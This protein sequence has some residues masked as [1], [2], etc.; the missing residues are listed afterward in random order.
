MSNTIDFFQSE[1]SELAIPGLTA[2]VLL[3]GL[4]CPYL[5]LIEIVRSGWPNFSRARLA[6]NPAAC[7]D[8][9]YTT[10]EQIETILPFGKTVCVQQIYNSGT[11]GISL[12]ALPIFCGQIQRIESKFASDGEGVEIIASDFSATLRRITV[13]GRWVRNIDGSVLFMSGLDTVFNE[14]GKPNAAQEPIKDN[15]NN[16]TVF[17]AGSSAGKFWTYA[18]VINYLFSKYLH[19]GQLQTPSIEQLEALTGKQIIRDLDLTG[20]NLL[21]A[22]YCCCQRVGLNFKFVPR[23]VGTGCDQAA[24]FYK[25]GNGREMELNCQYSNQLFSISKTNIVALNSKKHCWPITHKYVGQG[26]FKLYEAT[27]E[28]VKAWDPALEDTNYDKFSPSTNPNF[29]QVK[30]VYRKWCLNEAGDYSVTPYNQGEAFDFSKIFECHTFVSHNRRFWPAL[31]TDTQKRSLGYFLQVSFDSGQTWRQYLYA[32]NNLL[33]ECGIWLSSDQLDV[34][35]WTAA[36]NG[37]LR[38]RITASVFSDERLGC[39]VADG[40]LNSTI[41]AVEHIITLPRQFKYRKVSG[42]SIF[43]NLLDT[44]L[45]TPD[46]VDDSA[47][48]VEFVRHNAEITSDIIETVKVQ[49]AYLAFDYEIGDR[50]ISSAESRDLF[51]YRL[52]SRSISWI[53]SIQ[54]DFRNQSVTLKIVRKRKL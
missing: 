5:E 45:G 21:E 48:L 6:Y 47:A 27:F 35:T 49:T 51:G 34:E 41:P 32:F 1:Q 18:E 28:L 25:N 19:V 54:M 39:E 44:S 20:L 4:L 24:V 16:L 2:S 33:D 3:D 26:N 9:N 10:L 43:A 31:T 23:P 40:P 50:V 13:Y 38:L 7:T 29:Y 17:A 11:P 22:L 53:D 12:S 8:S 14:D 30:D 42:A 52:D 36:L 37:Q 15:G 46:E